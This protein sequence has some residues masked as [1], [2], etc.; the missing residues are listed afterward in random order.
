[1][2]KAHIAK[3]MW[4]KCLKTVSG[5]RVFRE[6]FLAFIAHAAMGSMDFL[7]HM[8]CDPTAHTKSFT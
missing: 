2:Q 8:T 4:G 5:K 3:A 1:L 6:R 7:Q